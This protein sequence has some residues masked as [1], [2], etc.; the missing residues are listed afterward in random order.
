[1]S[2]DLEEEAERKMMFS[3]RMKEKEKVRRWAFVRC[4][5]VKGESGVEENL[6]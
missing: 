3:R 1:M 4:L 5:R 2:R 6:S